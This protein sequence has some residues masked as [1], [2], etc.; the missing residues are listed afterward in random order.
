MVNKCIN[1]SKKF[2]D[3]ELFPMTRSSFEGRDIYRPFKYW[4]QAEKNINT[5]TTEMDYID[6]IINMNR[7]VDCRMKWLNKLY[8]FKSMK[9]VNYRKNKMD[10]L[11]ALRIIRSTMILKLNDLRNSL[12]H[13]Y[14]NP[15][16]KLRCFEFLDFVWYFLKSSNYLSQNLTEIFDLESPSRNKIGPNYW[17]SI[18]P[19][20]NENWSFLFRGWVPNHFIKKDCQSDDIEVEIESIETKEE[21]EIK[22][23]KKIKKTG[24]SDDWEGN[25]KNKKDFYIKGNFI[26]PN[27]VLIFITRK[28]F[29]F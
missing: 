23:N 11:E 13:R 16:N 20:P 28:Y 3:W 1:L 2:L 29:N 26:G 24:S 14:T 10:S 8:Q 7:E 21:L 22:R 12:E 18:E 9:F 5:A 17:V 6:S 19:K 27:D 25:N 15:P 4:Q